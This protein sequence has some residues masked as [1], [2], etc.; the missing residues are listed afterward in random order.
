M[1]NRETTPEPSERAARESSAGGGYG[2]GYGHGAGYGA[3][4][5]GAAGGVGLNINPVQTLFN[6]KI[7]VI[8][9]A[10]IG[11]AIG[12]WLL[13]KQ[14]DRFRVSTSLA[15]E[16]NLPQ[17]FD[18]REQTVSS[19]LPSLDVLQAI[20]LSD[21]AVNSFV[22]AP[23]VKSALDRLTAD[24]VSLGDIFNDSLKLRPLTRGV[25]SQRPSGSLMFSLEFTQSDAELC[26]AAV[27]ALVEG[28][29]IYYSGQQQNF[30][31]EISSN[32]IE[33]RDQLLPQLE[34]LEREYRSFRESSPLDWSSTGEAI[35]PHRERQIQ[36]VTRRGT[37]ESDLLVLR[38]RRAAIEGAVSS[39]EDPVAALYALTQM[40]G[41]SLSGLESSERDNSN[42]PQERDRDL[43]LIN[44]EERLIPLMIEREQAVSQFGEKHFRVR[45]IEDQIRVARELQSDLTE[46]M[47]TRI[48]D[49]RAGRAEPN[50]LQAAV[51]ESKI[52]AALAALDAQE[53]S[54]MLQIKEVNSL[55]EQ[56]R[57][58]AMALTK[59]ESDNR[60][61]MRNIERRQKLL[62][63]VEVKLSELSLPKADSRIRLVELR[64]PGLAQQLPP[65]WFQFLGIGSFAGMAIGFGL[66]LLIDSQTKSFKS[67]DEVTAHLER[68][69]LGSL[70]FSSFRS[71]KSVAPSLAKIDRSVSIVHRPHSPF[72]EIVRRIRTAVL[73]ET[74]R[75]GGKI[76]QVTSA[77]P[78]EGKTT[79]TVNL[80]TSL[81][82]A[83]K[84]V[85][86]VDCDLRR[87]RVAKVLGVET[88]HGISSVL[89]GDIRWSDAVLKTPILNLSLVASGPVPGNPAEALTQGTLREN[90]RQMAE[91]FDYVIIDTPPLLAVTDPC[92]IADIADHVIFVLSL[93]RRCRVTSTEAIRQLATTKADVLG[94]VVNTTE[95]G[96]NVFGNYVMGYNP[97]GYYSYESLYAGRYK[98]DAPTTS[99]SPEASSTDEK[100]AKG[101]KSRR[102]DVKTFSVKVTA[103]SASGSPD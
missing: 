50:E 43:A 29:K 4:N 45:Q 92:L 30:L 51:A 72:S 76:L 57:V 74:A 34:S 5:S 11:A 46:Q 40:L 41:S 62:D 15:V 44:I 14:P 65:K 78:G 38:S 27:P 83:G 37:L 28:L 36:L 24:G 85:L 97:G 88:S 54:M 47:L 99:K 82:I 61:Y 87:P 58:Q 25:D 90:L 77:V 6:H 100:K 56:E 101:G 91:S 48:S 12:Y 3:D 17:L 1:L 70:P 8:F 59:L 9:F 79:F 19:S 98:S 42:I 94:I 2:Y 96:S 89:N 93:K 55:I 16:S 68:P 33:M 52:Q 81:A 71:P 75:T 49:L 7:L 103:E 67:A 84:R 102:S 32:I 69:T 80:A 23:P 26:E 95:E 20:L 18:T 60:M 21:Q 35:N 66:G 13:L 64:A 73:L 10:L 53:K 39:Q 86:L 31:K 22:N 63:A